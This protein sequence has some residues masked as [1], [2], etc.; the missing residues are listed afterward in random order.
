MTVKINIISNIYIKRQ[1][2]MCD[3]NTIISSELTNRIKGQIN[4]IEGTVIKFVYQF[5]FVCMLTK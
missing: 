3:N 5:I 1:I 4:I 2:I